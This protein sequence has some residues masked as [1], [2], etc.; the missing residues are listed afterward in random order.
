MKLKIKLIDENS[1]TIADL[2]KKYDAANEALLKLQDMKKEFEAKQVAL[3]QADKLKKRYKQMKHELIQI[4]SLLDQKVKDE[5]EFK[6][7]RH[8]FM[9]ELEETKALVEG[10]QKDLEI[11][12]RNSADLELKLKHSELQIDYAIKDKKNLEIGN[13]RLKMRL[14]SNNPEQASLDQLAQNKRSSEIT[15]EVHELMHQID[16]LKARVA[17]ESYYNNIFKTKLKQN[18]I[19]TDFLNDFRINKVSDENVSIY[20]DDQDLI[21]QLKEKLDLEKE[22]NQRLQDHNVQLQKDLVNYKSKYARD[23]M[24][25]NSIDMWNNDSLE[26]KNKYQM[27][28]VEIEALKD[29][30]KVLRVQVRKNAIVLSDTHRGPLN[31][32]TNIENSVIA[33][34]EHTK[35]KQENLRLRSEINELKTRLQRFESGNMNRFEQEEEIIQLKNSIKSLQLKNKTLTANIDVYKNRSELYYTKLSRSEVE[36]ETSTKEC[37]K[38]KDDLQNYKAKIARLS[39]Q[40][41]GSESQCQEMKKKLR[42]LE[43]TLTDK[44]LKLE[45]LDE[46]VESLKEKLDD[47]EKLRKTV[48]SVNYEFQESEN[49][50]LNQELLK[51]TN[52][53]TELNKML[54]SLN[55]QLESSRKEINTA[56]FNNNELVKRENVLSKSLNECMAKNS[57][58]LSEIKFRIS[59]AKNLSQQVNVLKA[60]NSNLS[61]ERDDLL[62]SKQLLEEKLQK[63]SAEFDEHL[64]KVREDVNHSVIAAQL[65]VELE[66]YQ[67]NIKELTKEIQDFRAKYNSVEEELTKV[68][69]A[70]ADVI[71]ENKQLSKLNNRLKENLDE[72]IRKF[73]AEMEAQEKHWVERTESLEK[74]L[75]LSSCN[76]RDESHQLNVL[77]RSI[78]DLEARNSDLER[79]KKHAEDEIKHLDEVLEKLQSNYASLSKREMEAQFQCK[80]LAKNCEQLREKIRAGTN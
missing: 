42:E 71:E 38:L 46:T 39:S 28:Q 45:Q 65:K 67:S 56:K 30:L 13:S 40:F 54:K 48:K 7:G 1:N 24:D 8:H 43:N 34:P 11:E 16:I 15:P 22:A 63:I 78:K 26:Y 23:S 66:Q 80:Q 60:T 44:E 77:R 27:A 3:D 19:S 10:L 75:F 17:R 58:L 35:A 49:Q 2:Q 52:I 29:Q 4:K 55:S 73:K 36:L 57:A 33:D 41:E 69:D 53:Q 25:S 74:E 31:D 37:E 68:K 20:N 6:E 76:K 61:K 50:R 9:K 32:T 64:Q 72:S 70:Y 12:K 18:N 5:V 59:E 14:F 21:E 62:S 79:S 47:S 51:S